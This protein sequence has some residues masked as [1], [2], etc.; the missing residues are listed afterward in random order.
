MNANDERIL[1]LKKQIAEKK[2][3]LAKAEKFEP[4]TN[5][6]LTLDGANCN[7]RVL[8]KEGL[9]ALIVK[10]NVYALSAKDLG[11]VESYNISGYNIMEWIEDI[12]NKLTFENRKE[13]ETKLKN[14]EDALT[15]LLSNE[16]KTELQID[17][18]AALLK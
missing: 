16:K 12:R 13:E 2:T 6:I 10:L 9:I 14:M 8:K 7:L 5:C 11:M 3:S 1:E 4:I 15:E 18:I 17:E